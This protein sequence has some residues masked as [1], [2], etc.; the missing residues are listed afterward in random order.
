MF[1][2]YIGAQHQPHIRDFAQITNPAANGNREGARLK[3]VGRKIDPRCLGADRLLVTGDI[4]VGNV[5]FT[6]IMRIGANAAEIKS[7]I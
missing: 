4:G 7:V 1:L 5:V 3:P 2:I 6:W